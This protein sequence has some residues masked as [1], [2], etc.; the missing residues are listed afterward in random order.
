MS[1][2]VTANDGT[3]LPIG[4]LPEI[5]EYAGGKLTR[6]SV[7]YQSVKYQMPKTFTQTLTWAAGGSSIATVVV[8]DGGEFTAIDLPLV[9][10]GPGSGAIF[11]PIMTLPAPDI[12]LPSIIDGGSGYTV[13]DVLDFLG[14]V[15]LGAAQVQVTSVDGGGA[16]TGITKT[17]LGGYNELPV[18]PVSASGGTG[19]GVKFD[20]TWTIDSIAVDNGGAGYTAESI[21]LFSGSWI[22]EPEVSF[23]FSS[24]PTAVNLTAVSRWEVQP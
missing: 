3:K 4:D 14:G 2:T 17:A 24:D 10:G 6:I 20:P 19:T 8:N 23:T 22:T 21:M 5:L 13:G 18:S 1:E 11:T 9:A 12:V 7:Q 16:V 15:F